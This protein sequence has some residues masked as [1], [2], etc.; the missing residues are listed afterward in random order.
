MR[1]FNLKKLVD[2]KTKNIPNLQLIFLNKGS[3]KNQFIALYEIASKTDKSF[4]GAVAAQERKQIKGLNN[5][6]KRLFKAEKETYLKKSI[7]Y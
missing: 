3:L 4:L 5:L 2:L 6:E 1:F 7:E